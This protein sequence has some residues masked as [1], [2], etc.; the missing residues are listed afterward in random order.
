PHTAAVG[1]TRGHKCVSSTG[2]EVLVTSIRDRWYRAVRH[3]VC[4]VPS[5]SSHRPAPRGRPHSGNRGGGLPPALVVVLAIVLLEAVVL[6]GLALWAVVELVTA[7][8]PNVGVA[9]FI[10]LFCAAVA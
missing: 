1:R 9:L 10:I 2:A 4:C 7:G 8:S 5:S 3:R 6:A